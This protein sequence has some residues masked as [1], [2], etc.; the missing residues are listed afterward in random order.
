MV[1]KQLTRAWEENSSILQLILPIIFPNNSP[2]AVDALGRIA[3]SSLKQ[4]RF[5]QLTPLLYREVT[6]RGWEKHL[7]PMILKLLWQDYVLALIR[8]DLED[9]E[10]AKIIEVFINAKI[11]VV[12]LKGADFRLRLYEESAVRPMCDI[13]LLIPSH[14]VPKARWIL[15]EL[16]FKLQQ[17]SLDPRP[18]FRYR[19]RNE[20]HF[21]PPPGMPLL[22]DLHWQINNAGRFY[23]LSSQLLKFQDF[24][25]KQ[26][27]LSIKV[28]SPEL[29]LIHQCLHQLY[30]GRIIQIIDMA[31]ILSTLGVDWP[32]FLAEVK[33]FGCQAPVYLVLQ[34]MARVFPGLVP[35][36]VLDDLSG[37]QPT[38]AEKLFLQHTLGYLTIHLSN[39]Y[40]HRTLSDWSF[41]IASVI[42]PS[43]EYLKN[44]YGEPNRRLFFRDILYTLFSFAKN[45][46]P[47]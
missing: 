36:M 4:L 18:G 26:Q 38:W 21:Y 29:A 3:P 12:L 31:L 34:Q 14:C 7:D 42:W 40:H 43:R 2:N 41:Y 8:A 37:Y 32:V 30:E 27:Q 17:D 44:L 13:D 23:L 39:L 1:L 33:T 16:G 45:W 5:H 15:K 6:R 28:L 47:H 19:F 24:F 9:R 46:A 20:L 22:I 10:V 25:W 35:R 11:E